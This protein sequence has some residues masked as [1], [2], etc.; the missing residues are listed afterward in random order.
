MCLVEGAHADID[1]GGIDV[2]ATDLIGICRPPVP[3]VFDAQYRATLFGGDA[4]AQL[5]VPA[6]D[7][8]MWIMQPQRQ[9][10]PPAVAR[11]LHRKGTW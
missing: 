5:P 11:P 6:R 2:Q 3:L 4:L 9:I 10:D 8:D 7:I 1:Q